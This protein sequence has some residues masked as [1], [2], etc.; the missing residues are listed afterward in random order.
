[1]PETLMARHVIGLNR[2]AIGIENIGNN[3]LTRAQLETNARLIGS[4]ARRFQIQYL[5]GHLEY[6]RFKGSALWEERE[7]EYFTVKPD[8]GADFMH[9]LRLRLTRD[10]LDFKDRP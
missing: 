1:M 4:L 7:S 3:D 9:R 8:P 2:R 5:I 6:G 10:G